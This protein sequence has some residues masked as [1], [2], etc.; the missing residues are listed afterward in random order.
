V[1]KLSLTKVKKID[2]PESFLRR[3]VLINN[4]I[5]RLQ[6][7]VRD[8]KMM[9]H[10]G[11]YMSKLSS[12]R[13][14]YAYS[15]LS[16]IHY[17][18]LDEPEP[19]D[20]DLPQSPNLD[21]LC[22]P[23][24]DIVSSCDGSSTSSNTTVVI[25]PRKR[26]LLPTSSEDDCDVNDVLSHF[27]IPPTP[28]IIS[29]IDEDVVSSSSTTKP[30]CSPSGDESCS[31]LLSSSET[32]EEPVAKKARTTEEEA[33]SLLAESSSSM[34]IDEGIVDVDVDV[35][36]DDDMDLCD[37]PQSAMAAVL[38]SSTKQQ[39]QQ[40]VESALSLESSPCDTS[41]GLSTLGEDDSDDS[42]SFLCSSDEE[43]TTNP[44]DENETPKH[45]EFLKAMSNLGNRIS[46]DGMQCSGSE[47]D[48]EDDDGVAF[49][50]PNTKEND[51]DLSAG[52]EE[53][54]G[55][56]G[57]NNVLLPRSS[58]TNV[59]CCCEQLED[60]TDRSYSLNCGGR[61][62]NNSSCSANFGSNDSYSRVKNDV[63]DSISSTSCS[64]NTD[65]S[66]SF[67]D[68]N[69]GT[70]SKARCNNS[71]PMLSTS[72]SDEDNCSLNESD[73]DE[74]CSSSLTA[75]N[76]NC[77]SNG[78]TMVTVVSSANS[79]DSSSMEEGCIATTTDKAQQQYSSCGH[80]SMFGEL[81]SVVFHSLIASLE[82]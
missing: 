14:N 40:R 77:T 37:W 10:G 43:T 34:N 53:K 48:T 62:I 3:S 12:Y 38:L 65:N 33:V 39:Q 52:H 6:K 23:K 4:T 81:Q 26:P 1:L 27:Y 28:C 75:G 30:S 66:S 76:E 32:V 18:V 15:R 55:L 7:E 35:V 13:K 17:S 68:D 50:P 63:R 73:K 64:R 19:A 31:L 11:S 44:G 47:S 20:D 57:S 29:S 46:K 59:L 79:T 78:S 61:N 56:G 49:S 25:S 70:A 72:S 71:W 36:G 69:G 51:E 54:C 8:E 67:G 80:S 9:R 42:G 60:E 45:N 41:V 16:D 58:E 82:S 24:E 22:A 74:D 5:K 2:D 21:S